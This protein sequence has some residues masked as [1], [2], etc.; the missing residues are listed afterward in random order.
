MHKIGFS[1]FGIRSN[2]MSNNNMRI[3]FSSITNLT[4]PSRQTHKKISEKYSSENC[5][6]KNHVVVK[7]LFNEISN[8]LFHFT[9]IYI[10]TFS[11]G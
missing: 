11:E 2:V 3:I 9:E 5:L 10:L 4:T 7:G 6:M 8:S 1:C